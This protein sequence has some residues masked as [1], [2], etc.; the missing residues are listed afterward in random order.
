MTRFA[1]KNVL[2]VLPV[3]VSSTFC[4][5]QSVYFVGSLRIQA[6]LEKVSQ[7]RVTS[8]YLHWN[9]RLSATSVLVVV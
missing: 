5:V 8:L 9:M 3:V 7:V 6:P 2:L 1:F 4:K